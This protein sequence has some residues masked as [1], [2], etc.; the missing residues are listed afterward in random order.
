MSENSA[1]GCGRSAEAMED[2]PMCRYSNPIP[3]CE[4]KHGCGACGA[5][6]LY[7]EQ[8]EQ[9]QAALACQNQILVDLLGAVNSLTATLLAQRAT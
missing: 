7:E 4:H 2:V 9:I 1:C 3:T 8:L 5:P 6:R